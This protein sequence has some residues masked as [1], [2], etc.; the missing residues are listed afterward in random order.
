MAHQHESVTTDPRFFERFLPRRIR[1]CARIEWDTVIFEGE[2]DRIPAIFQREPHLECVSI[3]RPVADDVRRDLLE[4][5]LG[6]V[7]RTTRE[8]VRI[9]RLTGLEKTLREPRMRA[10]K[11]DLD[12]RGVRIVRQLAGRSGQP[13]TAWAAALASA[14]TGTMSFREVVSKTCATSGCAP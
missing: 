7:S 1:A 12:A 6:V 2:D 11:P 3:R 10:G 4:H 14:R 9:E 13:R 8:P 5:Q